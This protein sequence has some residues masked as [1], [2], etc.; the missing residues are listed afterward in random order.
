MPNVV[1]ATDQQCISY[2]SDEIFLARI[3]SLILRYTCTYLHGGSDSVSTSSHSQ[4]VLVEIRYVLRLVADGHLAY[5]PAQ[6]CSASCVKIRHVVPVVGVI[7]K[8]QFVLQRCPGAVMYVQDPAP[9]MPEGDLVGLVPDA[10]RVCCP[11]DVG[12]PALVLG[13]RLCEYTLTVWRCE[14]GVGPV[15]QIGAHV[16]PRDICVLRGDLIHRLLPRS[17]WGT[18]GNVCCN[19]ARRRTYIRWA[20]AK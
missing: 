15:V 4:R 16:P 10:L 1:W 8:H 7:A 17:W 5:R 3:R 11:H 14:D 13:Q 19:P 6:D 9:D 20:K 2:K 18:S 12:H